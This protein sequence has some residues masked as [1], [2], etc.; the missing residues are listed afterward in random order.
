MLS[1]ALPALERCSARRSACC[2]LLDMDDPFAGHG[3]WAVL[4]VR[5]PAQ[6]VAAAAVAVRCPAHMVDRHDV[7]QAAAELRTSVMRRRA[8]PWPRGASPVVLR[9]AV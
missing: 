7:G 3:R 6:Q 9:Q 8:V 5:C 4:S 1:C 2:G